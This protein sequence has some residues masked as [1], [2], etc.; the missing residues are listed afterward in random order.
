MDH[1]RNDQ[2]IRITG[3]DV[4]LSEGIETT[5]VTLF[6]G[7]IIAVGHEL[8]RTKLDE[9]AAETGTSTPGT[10][11]IDAS[12]LLLAP[13]MIDVHG[14]A[15]ERQFMP[16]PGV[17]FPLDIATLETDRQLA[18]NGIATAYH[19]LTLSWEPGL[20]SLQ[21]AKEFVEELDTLK[22][23]LTVDNRLQ[24]RWETYAF[25][26]EEMIVNLLDNESRP[27]LAFNDHTSMIMLDPTVTLQQRPFEQ[28]D[29][30]P[31]ADMDDPA[32]IAKLK[33]RTDRSGLDRDEYTELLTTIWQRRAEVPEKIA[34]LALKAQA[35]NVPMLSHDDSQ[36]ET[37]QYYHSLGATVAEFPM[38][39]SVAAFACENQ[40]A[41]V[42]GAPN[43]LRGGSHMGSPGAAEMVAAE[44]CHILASDYYYPSML[45]AVAK[46][47]QDEVQP[48]H[49]LWRLVSTNPA[50]AMK[51]DDRG[52]I[53]TGM[54]SLIHI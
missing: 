32:F 50:K 43:V 4:V 45:G 36:I 20:R 1:L 5:E 13:A 14:D 53:R 12:G 27:S 11:H 22:E 34:K 3:A 41:V 37:R 31:V 18:S 8:T 25:E 52:E 51:L 44:R 15:F 23:R 30:F 24:L 40:D 42:F 49:E 35:N 33:I 38:R 28:S 26:A 29:G 46:L 2:V 6:R 47:A 39:E 19:A 48:L 54:L 17:M 16:R 7:E 9:I 21:T 10:R